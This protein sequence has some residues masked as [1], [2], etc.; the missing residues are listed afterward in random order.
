MF[1]GAKNALKTNKIKIILVEII[2]K[3]KY[4]KIKEKKILDMLKKRNFVLI[5]KAKILSISMFSN[6]KGG[7]YLFINSKHLKS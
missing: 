2:D 3:K 4:H 7:D 5:K 6:I 1:K